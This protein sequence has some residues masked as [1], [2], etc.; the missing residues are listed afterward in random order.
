MVTNTIYIS[1]RMERRER[2]EAEIH[3][4]EIRKRVQQQ[5]WSR[6]EETDF[7][8]TLSSFGV[9][10]DKTSRQYVWTTFKH[11]AHLEKKYDETLTEYFL[12]FH[13]MLQLVCKRFKT[14]EEGILSLPL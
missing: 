10:Q 1:Q 4:R 6:R 14:E 12:A 9:E 8:K 7:Y 13:H 11:L 5:R 3:E 2:F